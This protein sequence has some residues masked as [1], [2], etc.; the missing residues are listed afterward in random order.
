MPKNPERLHVTL[1]PETVA[2]YRYES[3]KK[4]WL[5][6]GM[7]ALRNCGSTGIISSLDD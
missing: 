2:Q 5:N 4:L 7:N 3:L 6:T 1:P